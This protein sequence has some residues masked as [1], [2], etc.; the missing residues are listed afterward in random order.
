MGS[1]LAYDALAMPGLA[2][3]LAKLLAPRGAVHQRWAFRRGVRHGRKWEEHGRAVCR[4]ETEKERENKVLLDALGM[5]AFLFVQCR[6]GLELGSN[7]NLRRYALLLMC[8]SFQH[9]WMVSL[10]CST[11]WWIC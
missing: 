1:D 6:S 4:T 7:E 5:F 9:R 8:S 10:P 3:A 2:A 11:S